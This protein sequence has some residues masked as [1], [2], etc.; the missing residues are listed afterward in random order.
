MARKKASPYPP[1]FKWRDGR[2]RW[3]PGPGIR[4]AGFRGRDLR[5][6]SGAWL[7]LEAAIAAAE[8]LNA[9]VAAWRARGAPRRRPGEG[10][11]R[12]PNTCAA[13]WDAYKASPKW[14]RLASS[15]Q[16]DYENKARVWL[17]TFGAEP[18][19]ALRHHHLYTWW[20]RQHGER[21]HAMANGTI[22]VARLALSHAVR[23][24]WLTT[25]PARALA[26]DGVAP[27]CVVWSPTELAAL[28][29]CAD[30][31][32][33][34]SVGDAVVVAL[35]TGQRQ[36]DV[37]ALKMGR[38]RDGWCRFITGKTGARV[39]VPMTPQLEARLAAIKARRR[40]PSGSVVPF[41]IDSHVVLDERG[42]QYK[43]DWFRKQWAIV[44]ADVARELPAVASKQFL[45]LRDTAITRLALA[46]CTVPQIRAI[47]GHSMETIHQ[48]LQ[49]Y[50]VLDD[51]LAIGAIERLK[52]W[53]A[54]EGIAI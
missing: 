41:Q 10:V 39:D 5:D 19:A 21:G 32:G 54:E 53:M 49:H 17:D 13:L 3:E 8:E 47:T 30:N 42:N 22:A 31:T 18:A 7:R 33:L 36:G 44:R 14:S 6:A 52:T 29:R 27:R 20:E 48:V 11:P 38:A 15:T 40:H 4:D 9:E 2:P 50:L 23:L 43:S 28:I 37:L 24:G 35:H 46:G 12:N 51:A 16:K 34:P 26:L 25:N 45:D 1:Y